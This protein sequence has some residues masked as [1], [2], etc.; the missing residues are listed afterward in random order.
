MV[1]ELK[2]GV[3]GRFCSKMKLK[4]RKK[5][6]PEGRKI[7][8]RRRTDLSSIHGVAGETRRD[9]YSA[10]CVVRDTRTVE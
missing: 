3:V 7:T 5:K 8:T 4:M 6:V 10:L 1:M 9:K 2:H